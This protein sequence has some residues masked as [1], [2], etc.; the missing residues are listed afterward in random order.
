M[1][2]QIAYKFDCNSALVSGDVLPR[3]KR[4]ML[5]WI[6][7]TTH[8]QDYNLAI[9]NAMIKQIAYKFECKSALVSGDVLPRKNRSMFLDFLNKNTT[10]A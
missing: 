5:F 7:W 3:K 1:F 9:H 6:F 8:T 2:K 4:S 10:Q